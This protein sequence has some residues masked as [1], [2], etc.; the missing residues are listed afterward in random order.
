M[1]R[2]YELLV[3]DWD[4]TLMN[5]EAKIMRCL[6]AAAD[7]LGLPGPG[8][9]AMREVIGLGMEEA[10]R[11]LFPVARSEQQQQFVAHFREHYL[12]LDR[13]RIELFPGVSQGLRALATQGYLLAVATGRPR[14]GLERMLAQTGLRRLFTATRC[15]DEAPSKPH[16]QML[17]ELL[18]ATGIAPTH[19]L[20]VGDTVHDMEM[21][22]HAGVDGL[23]VGYGVHAR[24]RLLACGALACVDSFTGVCR[25]LD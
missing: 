6:A 21:A 20:M 9:D 4:G 22:R 2:R 14:R 18:A 15:A 8:E 12:H 13:A 1:K 25:W 24:E 10:A 11:R 19:A 7:A 16:P 5:S 3:F 23:G 17:S